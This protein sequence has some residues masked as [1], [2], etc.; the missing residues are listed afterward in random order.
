MPEPFAFVFV[1]LAIAALTVMVFGAWLAFSVVRMVFRGLGM[2]FGIGA[3]VLPRPPVPGRCPR[4]GC[5]QM[6][7]QS[8]RFCRRC[9]QELLRGYSDAWMIPHR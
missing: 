7:P 5:R 3:P 4:H 1:F 9:G 6:N 8:A 2:V